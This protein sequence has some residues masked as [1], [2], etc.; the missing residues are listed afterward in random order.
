MYSAPALKPPTLD[1][2]EEISKKLGL[3]IPLEDLKGHKEFLDKM[4]GQLNILKDI[5]EPRLP[6]RY[7]RTPGYRPTEAENALNGWCW[8]TDIKGSPTG[9]LSGKKVGIKDNIG[10]A[11]VPMSVGS[12]MMEGHMPEYDATVVSRIL[13]EGGVI[14]GKTTCED[15][16][17]SGSSATSYNGPVLNPHD[18]T[19]SSGG[20]SSGNGAL[21]ASGEIDMAIGSDQG[22]S[23]RI[24]AAWC[25]IVGIKPT[26]GLVPYTGALTL[27]SSIDHLGPMARTVYDCALLLEVIA[28]NDGLDS[29]QPMNIK[30]PEYTKLM[31]EEVSGMRVGLVKE[32][33]EKCD[34]DIERTVRDTVQQLKTKGTTVDEISIPMHLKG[35]SIWI[36]LAFQGNYKTLIQGGGSSGKGFYPTTTQDFLE[37][38][39]K[40]HPR[41][42]PPTIAP[43]LL[44]GEYLSQNY[45][46]H[47]YSKAKNLERVLT[48]AYNTALEQYD[49]LMMP[50]IC[51]RPTKLPPKDASILDLLRHCMSQGQ[52]SGTFNVTSHPALS[53]PVSTKDVLPVALQIIGKPF[54]ELSIFKL[55]HKIEILLKN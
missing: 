38:A 39:V 3:N 44:L 32:G 42:I 35:C 43:T 7:P 55:A 27:E 14:K 28:G 31:T 37:K 17:F 21:I 15:L 30:V 49:V 33:F 26:F 2:V 11:G 10:V 22:G 25:G 8:K 53:I 19:R 40:S 1:E 9:K 46:S 29:R 23:I 51:F 45:G 36:G 6:V 50:T 12:K 24:P 5:T 13:D 48:D 20:S 41:D 54:D 4:C 52:N 16:C 18:Q 34:P 47:F